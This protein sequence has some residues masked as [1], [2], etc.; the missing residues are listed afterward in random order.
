MTS[1]LNFSLLMKKQ[2]WQQLPLKGLLWKEELLGVQSGFNEED[3]TSTVIKLILLLPSLERGIGVSIHSL[4][5]S[6]IQHLGMLSILQ[7]LGVFLGIPKRALGLTNFPGETDC[8]LAIIMIQLGRCL[9]CL[10]CV[11]S[12]LAKQETQSSCGQADP[13]RILHQHRGSP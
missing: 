4:I 9:D 7:P 2:G 12:T 10:S 13:C 11:Q 5:D 8:H 1:A 6:Y 3:L